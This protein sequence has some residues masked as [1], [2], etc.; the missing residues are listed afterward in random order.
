MTRISTFCLVSSTLAVLAL[1]AN[2]A[3][4]ETITPKNPPKPKVT[5]HASGNSTTYK[6]DD[7]KS[8]VIGKM[9]KKQK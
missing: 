8:A 6:M 1:S 5:V 9:H 7:T 3:S 2:G 4:A